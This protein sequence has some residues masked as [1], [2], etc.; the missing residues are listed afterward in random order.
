MVPNTIILSYIRVLG[1]LASL[2]Q[3]PPFIL[4]DPEAPFR[5]SFNQTTIYAKSLF[6]TICDISILQR[7][8]AYPYLLPLIKKVSIALYLGIS[9]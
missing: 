3:R 2:T 8:K 1:S 9:L 4:L 6:L 7:A 5:A